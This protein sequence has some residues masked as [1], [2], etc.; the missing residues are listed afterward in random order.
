MTG[1]TAAGQASGF[2]TISVL[3][4]ATLISGS[5]IALQGTVR[6]HVFELLTMFGQQFLLM[7]LD[8]LLDPALHAVRCEPTAAAMALGIRL[9]EAKTPGRLV[10]GQG[11]SEIGVFLETIAGTDLLLFLGHDEPFSLNTILL[12]RPHYSYARVFW[13]CQ[14]SFYFD[15]F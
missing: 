6:Y 7:I 9:A 8:S 13:Q 2:F 14:T 10:A 4:S 11:T 1:R 3:P 5:Y 15:S 12:T